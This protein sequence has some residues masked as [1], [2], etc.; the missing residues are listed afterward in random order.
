MIIDIST[1]NN[2]LTYTDLICIKNILWA[3]SLQASIAKDV[4]ISTLSGKLAIKVTKLILD[5]EAKE[6]GN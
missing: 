2:E 3:H 6:Y 4:S 1:H 5:M